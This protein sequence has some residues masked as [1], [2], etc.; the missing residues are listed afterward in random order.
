MKNESIESETLI[1]AE[2]R[3]EEGMEET[4]SSSGTGEGG[5]EKRNGG[6]KVRTRFIRIYTNSF[7]ARRVFL[8][9]D[10]IDLV[11]W[12][13]RKGWRRE[14]SR[15]S[16]SSGAWRMRDFCASPRPLLSLGGVKTNSLGNSEG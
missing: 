7:E 1:N 9:P 12:P 2:S 10:A 16:L 3:G 13:S 6:D 4:L 14:R 8:A 5:I 15:F 11:C